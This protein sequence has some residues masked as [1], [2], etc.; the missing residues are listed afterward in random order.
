MLLNSEPSLIRRTALL[1]I[2]TKATNTSYTPVNDFETDIGPSQGIQS[3]HKGR[4]NTQNKDI[5]RP[6]RY[7]NPRN[8]LSYYSSGLKQQEEASERTINSTTV[9]QVGKR[10]IMFRTII[11]WLRTISLIAL[12]FSGTH[13][14]NTRF[15]YVSP[16]HVFLSFSFESLFPADPANP[17]LVMKFRFQTQDFYLLSE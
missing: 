10:L 17:L 7:I 6:R 4:C 14:K 15:V 13:K 11:H 8:I 16:S 9:F 3:T 1:R 5:T 12:D 2:D